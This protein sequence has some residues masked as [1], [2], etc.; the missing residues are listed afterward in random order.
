MDRKLPLVS[1]M[2]LLRLVMIYVKRS[3]NKIN[4]ILNFVHNNLMAPIAVIIII[5]AN[6]IIL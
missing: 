5:L 3:I 1:K 2:V 4:D 6:E